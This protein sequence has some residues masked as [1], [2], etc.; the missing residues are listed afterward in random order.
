MALRQPL[1]LTYTGP[2]DPFYYGDLLE[3]GYSNAEFPTAIYCNVDFRYDPEF[4]SG[5][6]YDLG[7]GWHI[8]TDYHFMYGL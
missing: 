6:E 8:Q 1:Y 2:E 7:D 5:G 3:I 4:S